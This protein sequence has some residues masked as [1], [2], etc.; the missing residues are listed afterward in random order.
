MVCV[1]IGNDNKV[2]EYR[3]RC[4][5]HMERDTLPTQRHEKWSGYQLNGICL[6]ED[7]IPTADHQQN[8]LVNGTRH[9]PKNGKN[10]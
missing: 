2:E 7:D 3:K 1:N 10:R 6:Q 5:L 4:I 8:G 9:D